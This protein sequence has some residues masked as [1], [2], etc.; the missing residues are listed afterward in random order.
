[1]NAI[2]KKTET[3]SSSDRSESSSNDLTLSLDCTPFLNLD[4]E[5]GL[6]SVEEWAIVFR[7]LVATLKIQPVLDD[8]LEAKAVDI[9][10]FVSPETEEEAEEYLDGLGETSE[11]YSTNFVQCIVVLVSS[12]SQIITEAS[13]R[14]IDNLI[15]FCSAEVRLALVQ[16][17]LLPQLITTLNPQSH[18]LQKP[19]ISSLIFLSCVAASLRLSSPDCLEELE[20][21]DVDEQ[22]AVHKT[23]LTKV[24]APSEQYICRLCMNRHSVIDG[25]LS[26]DFME[27]LALL[28][29]ICPYYQPTM[30]FVLHMPVFFTIPSCLTFFEDEKTIWRFLYQMTINQQKWNEQSG[31]V[32]QMEKEVHR[33]LRME[34]IEDVIEEKLRN[35]KNGFY[36]RELVANSII[37][38]NRQGMNLSYRL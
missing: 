15:E 3:I 23:V 28:L 10:K 34:G 4:E 32:Q 5:E 13:M 25:D 31:E 24:L 22:Q 20:I 19:L 6:D 14:M 9:L 17:E 2:T 1:M 36:G 11:E 12:P 27:L 18:P 26:D 16:A 8:S 21:E 37:W 35:D 33:M 7:S 30:E 29:R 38:N